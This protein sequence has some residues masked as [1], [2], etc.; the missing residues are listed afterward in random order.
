MPKMRF[1]TFLVRLVS[2]LSSF[3]L[4]CVFG[5]SK[6]S[7]LPSR[8]REPSPAFGDSLLAQAEFDLAQG[9]FKSAEEKARAV[10]LGYPSH[11]ALDE[12]HWVAAQACREK[13][14]PAQAVSYAMRIPKEYPISPHRAEALWLAAE[15]Y[16][17]LE[18]YYESADALS[19]L[20]SEPVA[21][22]D[23][24]RAL[25]AL[26]ELFHSHLGNREL[27]RLVETYPSSPLA[28]DISLGLAKREF[29]SGNYDRSYELLTN[30]LYQF[31]E[32]ARTPEARQLLELAAS[33]RDAPV[34]TPEYV[35][36]YRFG[37]LLPITGSLSRFGRY[38]QQ[39]VQLAVDEY[40]AEASNPVTIVEADT[41]GNPIDAVTAVR[42]L[43]YEEGV[44]GVLGSV[45][46][47]PSVAAATECNAHR[48]P[49]LS[50]VVSERRIEEIGR[51]IFHTRVPL[52]VE[53]SAMAKVATEDLLLKRFA[54]LAPTS[55]SRQELAHF[56]VQEVTHRGGRIVAEESF[57]EGDTDFREQL[58][59]IRESAPEALFIPADPEQLMLLLPQ[60]S[61]YDLQIQLLGL[62]DWNSDNLLRL[63]ER[64]LEG[65]LFPR[66]T[67]QGT[68]REAHRRFVAQ[69]EKRYGGDVHPVA[70]AG[71]FGMNMLLG[72]VD[73]GAL[74]REQFREFLFARLRAGV[75]ERMAEANSLSILRVSSGQ[76]REFTRR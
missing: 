29:V 66:E 74:D 41:K 64:E 17:E 1:G 72:A 27:E 31:P 4:L 23:E 44:V 3:A 53:V 43:V 51:W 58:E 46:S 9:N 16:R 71:Y 68:N 30:L 12:A 61:F 57:S 56:F 62:S 33:R 52:E 24:A 22:E 60:V 48:V 32:H 18:R 7:T 14:D 13:G 59:T 67:S 50:P 69:Y 25:A 11:H 38:F 42:K 76:V 36:P 35:E 15:A 20:L 10:I 70:A 55:A 34:G 19:M 5:C 75:E 65:A 8:A 39:G 49:L 21:V 2:A 54:V 47:V 37:I 40:N 63:S 45:F 28:G 6:P 73:A 26:K